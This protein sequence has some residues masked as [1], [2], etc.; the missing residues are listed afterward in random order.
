VA[1]ERF[2]NLLHLCVEVRHTGSNSISS[3]KV[4][5]RKI[6]SD[7]KMS[8]RAFKRKNAV[9]VEET[10]LPRERFVVIVEVDERRV[11]VQEA[12]VLRLGQ[13]HPESRQKRSSVAVAV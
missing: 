1:Q 13:R 11:E 7:V 6:R 8:F 4:W 12:V 9:H 5:L 2:A 10:L 3:L